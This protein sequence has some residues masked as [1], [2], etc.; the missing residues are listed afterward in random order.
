MRLQEPASNGTFHNDNACF[1]LVKG[2]R[3]DCYNLGSPNIRTSH[4]VSRN[5]PLRRYSLVAT[6]P[7]TLET[8]LTRNGIHAA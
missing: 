3:R 5:C 6:L 7:T 8:E 4:E 1:A 2:C